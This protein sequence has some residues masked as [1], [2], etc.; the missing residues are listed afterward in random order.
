MVSLPAQSVTATAQTPDESCRLDKWLWAV[1]RFKTRSL[2]TEAC[3]LGRVEVGEI[4]AKPARLLRAGDVVTVRET[5]LRRVLR[6]SGLPTSRVGPKLVAD[7][8]EDQTPPEEVAR[9]K[10]I[11][12]EQGLMRERGAGRP[13]KRDR[14]LL[15]GLKKIY[16]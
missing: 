11:R 6:V 10:E 1:R 9:I 8:C 7:F 14:R 13:T 4:E 2:A 15:D 16:E 3:R 5:G 12:A